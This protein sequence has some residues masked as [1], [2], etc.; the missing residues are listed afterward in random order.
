[1]LARSAAVAA[2]SI[3]CALA[4]AACSSSAAKGG[5]SGSSSAGASGSASASK[6]PIK[7]MALGPVDAPNF[8]LP[9]IPIGAQLEVDNIN[10]AGGVNGHQLQLIVCNDKNDPNTAA[11][12]ARQ[13]IQEKVV[14]L[15]GGLTLFDAQIVPLLDNA[16][17]PW[18]GPTNGVDYSSKNLFFVGGDAGAG[19]VG[20]GLAMASEGCKSYAVVASATSSPQVISTIQAGAKASGMTLA[21]TFK[22]PANSADW[23]P[24]AAAVKA[25]GADCIGSGTGPSESAGLVTAMR[26]AAPNIKMGFSSGGLPTQLISQLGSAANGIFEIAG[27]YPYSADKGDI[28]ALTKQLL[29][30]D[31]KSPLDTFT[32]S[33]YASVKIAAKVAQGLSGDITAQAELTGLT[34][35]KDFDTG[36]GP[37]VTFTTPNPVKGFEAL[38][39][40]EVYKLEVVNGTL[41]LASDT[42]L[43]AGPGLKYV[44]SS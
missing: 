40:P 5:G 34:K 19:W 28:Q 15:V 23:A 33:G 44:T 6:D 8:S 24:T 36:V 21:G 17:I 25:S 4:L 3:T 42:A 14:A 41:G 18:I 2:V 38:Y 35:L 16:N 27:Y 7:L 13:A 9:G 30:A 10:K 32:L 31:P 43:N 12:C 22:A 39:D 26:A 20:L 1:M 37:V 11:N 29:A